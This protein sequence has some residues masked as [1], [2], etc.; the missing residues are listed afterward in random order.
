[1]T[2]MEAQR[3]YQ[4]ALEAK[5]RDPDDE[6]ALYELAEARHHL[7]IAWLEHVHETP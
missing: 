2:V 4:L 6:D 7:E 1:M 3:Q 5:R